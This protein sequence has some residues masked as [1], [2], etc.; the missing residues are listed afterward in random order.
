M[1]YSEA[2]YL[3]IDGPGMLSQI[4]FNDS[5]CCC[6]TYPQCSSMAKHIHANFKTSSGWFG[7]KTHQNTQTFIASKEHIL[8]L[9]R[10]EM[11]YGLTSFRSFPEQELV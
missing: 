10:D 9:L 5:N 1:R 2:K 4:A 6:Q 3:A 11:I 7:H 8:L